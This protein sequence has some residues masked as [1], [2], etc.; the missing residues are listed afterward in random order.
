MDLT[1]FF[2]YLKYREPDSFDV[3]RM[4]LLDLNELTSSVIEDYLDYSREYTDKGVIKTR[5]EAAIKRRYSS[6]SSFFNYYY[7]LDMIDRNPVS[8]VTPPRIKKQYQITPSV[9]DFLN[10]FLYLLNGRFTEFLI[11]KV[12]A[13]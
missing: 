5:S 4:T 8:K 10:I 12:S 2:E 3:A 6:L 11:L 9:K 13:E 7:K 1:S